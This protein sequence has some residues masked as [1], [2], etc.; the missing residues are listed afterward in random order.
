MNPTRMAIKKKLFR[1]FRS[2]EASALVEILES[3]RQSLYDYMMRMT[4]QVQKSAETIEEVYV[5]LNEGVLAELQTYED[6]RLLLYTTTRKFSADIWNANTSMLE[7]SGILPQEES[8]P[9]GV[10]G[11]RELKFQ[12][13]LDRAIRG[14]KPFER[15][16]VYLRLVV[17]MAFSEVSDVVGNS[18]D[19]VENGYASAFKV[20]TVSIGKSQDEVEDGLHRISK[21]PMPPL[22]SP[23]T[24]NLSM[25]MEGIKTKPSGVWSVKRIIFLAIFALV[26]ACWFLFPYLTQD[27]WDYVLNL[28]RSR[29]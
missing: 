16:V 4:G 1:K 7:N 19:E 6:L 26:V 17:G 28:L 27:A 10:H 11:L 12:Q 14:L 23:A 20:L 2:G 8:D 29:P 21:H 13:D 22:S 9:L 25:V 18:Q 24:V 5:S 15:E 3:E